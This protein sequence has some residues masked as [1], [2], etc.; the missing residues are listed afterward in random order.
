MNIFELSRSD[1]HL[2]IDELYKAKKKGAEIVY[3]SDKIRPL[4]IYNIDSSSELAHKINKGIELP[5]EIWDNLA[6]V[7]LF[8]DFSV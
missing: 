5:R 8:F 1:L 7:K 2:L 6:V 4:S 3:G